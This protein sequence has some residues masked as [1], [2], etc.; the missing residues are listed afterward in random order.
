[1]LLTHFIRKMFEVQ[2][3][4]K[5]SSQNSVIQKTIKIIELIK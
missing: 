5:K 3:L 2:S 1:M 4:N